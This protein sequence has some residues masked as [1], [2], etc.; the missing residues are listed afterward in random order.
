MPRVI[1]GTAKGLRLATARGSALRPTGDRV[2]ESLFGTLGAL[3]EG[4]VVLDLCA[5]SGSLGIE[6]LSRGAKFCTFVETDKQGIELIRGNLDTTGLG[7]YARIIPM[8]AVEAVQNLA[9]ESGDRV[10]LIFA[11]P[12]YTDATLGAAIVQAVVATSVLAPGGVLCVER[13]RAHGLPEE[14]AALE[15]WQIKRYGRTS[16]V[17]YRAATP[18]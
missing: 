14:L 13:P 15:L 17:L 10:S 7:S 8:S 16:I 18:Q 6:A 9:R 12:P 3:V 1:A 11:D 2:K 4:A 5:G